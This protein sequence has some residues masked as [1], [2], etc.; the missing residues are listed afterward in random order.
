MPVLKILFYGFCN[1]EAAGASSAFCNLIDLGDVVGGYGQADL[2]L[3]HTVIVCIYPTVVK[4][5]KCRG[6][7]PGSISN[8]SALPN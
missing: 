6:L 1:D 5:K 8:K 4:R 2:L 7:A 3:T